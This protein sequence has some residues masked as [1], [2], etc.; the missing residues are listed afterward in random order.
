MKS[1]SEK[2]TKEIILKI[3]NEIAKTNKKQRS[4]LVFGLIGDLGSGKTFFVK[5]FLK[6]IGVKNKIASPTFVIMREYYPSGFTGL[7][8]YYKKT[9]HIDAYRLNKTEIIQA[10]N[11][12]KILK[13][14]K[15]IILI[16]WAGK[17]KKILPKE[18][19]WIYFEHGAKNNERII[20]VDN[21]H[22]SKLFK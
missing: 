20:K 7:S 18:T 13:E 2:Q 3:I 8:K 17:I 16:E 14:K 4:S 11:L 10:V 21:V 5:N 19:I 15:R 9:Y 12:T 22:F 1:N 6:Y